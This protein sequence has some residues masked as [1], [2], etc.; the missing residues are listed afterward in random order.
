MNA[1]KR[2]R[3]LFTAIG[4]VLAAVIISPLLYCV[5]ASFMTEQE[6]YASQVFPASFNLSNYAAALR[7]AFGLRGGEGQ[8]G[9][10]ARHVLRGAGPAPPCAG[11]HCQLS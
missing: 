5:S 6:L 1:S 11:G 3:L 8:L 7:V 4:L 10:L 2:S 9:A